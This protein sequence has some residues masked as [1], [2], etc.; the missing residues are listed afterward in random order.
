M[1]VWFYGEHEEAVIIFFFLSLSF[2]VFTM[3]MVYFTSTCPCLL[4]DSCFPSSF[5]IETYKLLFKSKLFALIDDV[6]QNQSRFN[7]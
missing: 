5:L 1:F 2:S 6:M 3:M 4:A 7:Y